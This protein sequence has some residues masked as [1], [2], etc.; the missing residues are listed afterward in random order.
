[1]HLAA[2]ARLPARFVVY[3]DRQDLLLAREAHRAGAFYEARHQVHRAFAAYLRA[4]LPPRDRR[5][6]QMRD[7]RRFMFRGG[8]RC[9]DGMG[10]DA[11]I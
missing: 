2:A 4:T 10:S 7:R 3:A 9:T 6:A 5:S 11:S 1:M 8:C